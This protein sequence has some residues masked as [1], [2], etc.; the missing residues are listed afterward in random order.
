MGVIE[1]TT[2]V[3]F[4][5][6]KKAKYQDKLLSMDTEQILKEADRLGQALL[7]SSYDPMAFGEEQKYDIFCSVVDQRGLYE[8][9]M[10]VLDRYGWSDQY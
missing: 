10:A 6:R 4:Y 5:D 3:N 7:V 9:S 1:R 8:L 2:P